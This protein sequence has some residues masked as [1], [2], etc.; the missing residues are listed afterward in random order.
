MSFEYQPVLTSD[1]VEL[2]P[3]RAEDYELLRAVAADPLKILPKPAPK[4]T[5]QVLPLSASQSAVMSGAL[6]R[7]QPSSRL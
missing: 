4:G 2:R 6:V 1:L 3:L 5:V 7:Y